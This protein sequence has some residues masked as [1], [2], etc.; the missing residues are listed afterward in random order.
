MTVTTKIPQTLVSVMTSEHSPL[1]GRSS[2]QT[3]VRELQLLAPSSGPEVNCSLTRPRLLFTP[4]W[5][6]VTRRWDSVEGTAESTCS[7]VSGH[8]W[9]I[10]RAI[11][12]LLAWGVWLWVWR[13]SSSMSFPS[14]HL[15][16]FFNI[17]L[18]TWRE[19]DWEKSFH[20]S[21]N[22]NI[23]F[24]A[25]LVLLI[26]GFCEMPKVWLCRLKSLYS[27]YIKKFTIYF[28]MHAFAWINK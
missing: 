19:R 14:F 1:S 11:L 7:G 25:Y 6:A 20:F 16:H 17:S 13:Y 10:A 26:D 2:R 12:P 3:S 5:R 18:W 24:E 9:V 27:I 28:R 15:F 22:Y 8:S 21:L 23:L 4:L